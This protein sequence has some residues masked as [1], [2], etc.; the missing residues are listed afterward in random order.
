[1]E[2]FIQIRLFWFSTPYCNG[3]NPLLDP[4]KFNQNPCFLRF[5]LQI[6]IIAF[7]RV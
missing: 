1:M 6:K 7:F 2:V 3:P 5:T 4:E